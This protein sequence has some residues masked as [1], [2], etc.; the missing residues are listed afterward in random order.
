MAIF[1]VNFALYSFDFS[2]VVNLAVIV[3]VVSLYTNSPCWQYRNVELS[4]KVCVCMF[5]TSVILTH[6]LCTL[7]VLLL[8]D[9]VLLAI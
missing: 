7:A 3:V 6:A 8:L 9:C 4:L 1:I 2:L 5:C